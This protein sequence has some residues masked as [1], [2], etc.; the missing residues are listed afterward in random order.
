MTLMNVH[1]LCF[2]WVFPLSLIFK[3]KGVICIVP[4]SSTLCILALSAGAVEHVD[5]ISADWYDSPPVSV[6]DLTLNH[7]MVMLH[8][9]SFVGVECPF[10]SITL[11]STLT[12][13][14]S[15]C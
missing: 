7:L 8:S 12:W 2:L 4:D 3:K 15:T 9:L 5:C 11:R 6:L 14:G 10:I 1:L 13:S